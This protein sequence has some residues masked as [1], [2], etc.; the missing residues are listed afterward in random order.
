MAKNK[1]LGR[2]HDPSSREV[3]SATTNRQMVD[4]VLQHCPAWRLGFIDIDHEEWGWKNIEKN[5]PIEVLKK[6][7]DYETRKW[8]EIRKDKKRDHSVNIDDLSTEAKKRLKQLKLDDYDS[9]FRF[10]LSATMRIWGILDGYKF[11]I[12]WLDPDHTVCPSS[13]R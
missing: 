2:K 3:R 12:L 6:L 1:R 5:N 7:K 8:H 10:R 9:L 13:E 11:N 4:D